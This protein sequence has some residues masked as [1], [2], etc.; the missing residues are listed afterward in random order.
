VSH[1]LPLHTADRLE[2]A[3]EASS[4]FVAARGPK[5]W[6]MRIV[7]YFACQYAR[8]VIELL[9]GLLAEYRAGTLVLPEMVDDAS[10]IPAERGTRR[11]R[12]ASRSRRPAARGIHA[13]RVSASDAPEPSAPLAPLRHVP[14]RRAANPPRRLAGDPSRVPRW[15]NEKFGFWA[16]APSHAHFITLSKQY[17]VGKRSVTHHLSASTGPSART[18]HPGTP[19]Q[20]PTTRSRG[21]DIA[22]R[23][24]MPGW[25]GAPSRT[26][27]QDHAAR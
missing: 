17:R 6:V 12:P 5:G 16:A 20:S 9:E 1:T 23:R 11:R 21:Q 19:P 7:A 3:F 15:S 24:R 18:A 2:R 27:R 4:R 10:P 26:G 22:S 25:R 14:T 8:A 13:P